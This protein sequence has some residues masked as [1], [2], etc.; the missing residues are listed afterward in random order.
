MASAEHSTEGFVVKYSNESKNKFH[1]VLYGAD[2]FVSTHIAWLVFKG[3]EE[4]AVLPD[5]SIVDFSYQS[6]SGLVHSNSIS[7]KPGSF[8]KVVMDPALNIIE[9]I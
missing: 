4:E 1:A 5:A 6:P 9:G 3:K 8:L 2:D 7:V